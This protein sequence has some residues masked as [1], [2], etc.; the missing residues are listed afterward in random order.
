MNPQQLQEKAVSTYLIPEGWQPTQYLALRVL[1]IIGGLA[2][3]LHRGQVEFP[4]E[5]LQEMFLLYAA[6]A[7]YKG[8]IWGQD[9]MYDHEYDPRYKE[10]RPVIRD[11][12]ISNL[13]RC[14]NMSDDWGLHGWYRLCWSL[15]LD[16]DKVINLKL[17]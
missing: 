5:H 14:A 6:L 7:Y 1:E 16:P 2:T 17:S 8:S 11:N 13:W 12:V 15:S 3:M 9:D 10:Q 4:S